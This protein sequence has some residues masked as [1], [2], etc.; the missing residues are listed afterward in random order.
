MLELEELRL[1]LLAMK[2]Q[3]DDLAD[4]LG[5]EQCRAEIKRLEAQQAD[6]DFFHKVNLRFSEKCVFYRSLCRF[7]GFCFAS[8]LSVRLLSSSSARITK[9]MMVAREYIFGVTVFLVML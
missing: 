1:R 6:P 8:L 2:P 9:K 7:C 3:I 4:A 5:L